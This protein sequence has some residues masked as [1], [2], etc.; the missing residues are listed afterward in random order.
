MPA[1]SAR[2]FEFPVTIYWEDTDAGFTGK[3]QE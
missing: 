3:K 1:T 2:S